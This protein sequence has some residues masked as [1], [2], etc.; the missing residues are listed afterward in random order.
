MSKVSAPKA[1]ADGLGV[2]LNLNGPPLGYLP[3]WDELVERSYER[4]QEPFQKHQLTELGR[5][6]R[7]LFMAIARFVASFFSDP[8]Y[9]K[10]ITSSWK[11]VVEIIGTQVAEN[12]VL[13]DFADDRSPEWQ[14]VSHD[15]LTHLNRKYQ[16]QPCTLQTS[17]KRACLVGQLLAPTD[18]ILLLGDDDFVSIQLARLGYVDVTVLDIDR[19]VLSD[20]RSMAEAE[21][22]G[23]RLFHH[24]LRDKPTRQQTDRTYKMVLIDPIYSLEGI[25]MFLQA[26]Q[27][28]SNPL[29]KPQILLSIHLMSLMSRGHSRFPELLHEFGCQLDKFYHSSNIYL[30]PKKTRLLIQVINRTLVGCRAIR[31]AGQFNYFTSDALLLRPEGGS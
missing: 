23:I 3:S 6:E 12:V 5:K 25:R 28:L 18:P 17:V 26:A 16:Q 14:P 4:F 29:M 20:I 24:D 2:N 7:K 22:H 1:T 10:F 30:V 27:W 15:V 19:R 31:S 13:R 11:E 9:R 21:G 8:T